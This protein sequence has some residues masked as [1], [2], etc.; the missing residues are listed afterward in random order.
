MTCPRTKSSRFA[1]RPGPAVPSAR[2][3]ATAAAP[4]GRPAHRRLRGALASLTV[5]LL[6]LEAAAI[7]ATPGP[8]GF[9]ALRD[10]RLDDALVHFQKAAEA[11]PGDVR[12]LNMVGAVLCMK[13][14]PVSSIPYFEK[15]LALAPGFTPAR[16]NLAMAEFE[17]GR[18]ES[19]RA[20]FVELLDVPG[21]RGL[22][23]LF[24]G[25]ISSEAGE[26]REAVRQ[27]E[28]AGDL[29]HSQPRAL[30]AY[31]RSL[32]RLGLADLAR[33][34][35]GSVTARSDLSGPDLVDLAQVSASVGLVD[36]A[37]EALDRAGAVDAGVAG[38]AVLRIKILTGAGREGE[39]LAVARRAAAGNPSQ[40]PLLALAEMEESAGDLDA[41]VGA[42][43][44]AVQVDPTSEEGYIVL[45]EFCV[46][47]RNPE[48][49]LEILDLGLS[50]ISGSYR[51][52][53]QKG[54]TLG[55]GQRF[56]PAK[57]AFTA[58]IDLTPDHAVA[59]TAQAVAFLLSDEMPRALETL[60]AGVSRFPDDFYVHYVY[61]FAL[62]RS[63][64]DGA[65]PEAEGLARVH[66]RRAI[67]LNA[68]FPSAHYRLGKILAETSPHEAID[69]LEAAVRLSPSLVAA[70]YQLGQL[71][72]A[73]GRSDEG[74]ALMQEV[75]DAKQRDLE[76]EQ[77]PQFRAFKQPEDP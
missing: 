66:L 43:R 47:Y 28:E 3:L 70:K 72:F 2:A 19:A 18:S 40:A 36:E 30:I 65:N 49:A 52:L 55:Q 13:D 15:A 1:S 27:L 64:A 56:E 53:V 45:S 63:R 77:M 26:D 25:M 16:K 24:L 57:E 5:L 46:R 39:A 4:R 44:K 73:S 61:G 41:A 6:L 14:D 32:Q 68:E 7:L 31:G 50:R 59:L 71:Y 22:A 29:A 9:E 48:L 74:A 76:A 33:T 75:G 58:A 20:R 35:L 54:I 37:L 69:H 62:D 42:L 34:A 8:D 51:L 38:L 10:G 23:N 60:R 17:L 11:D 12:A 67:E 21:E